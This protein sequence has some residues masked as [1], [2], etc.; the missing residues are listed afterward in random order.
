[1]NCVKEMAHAVCVLQCWDKC[2]L[3]DTAVW[4]PL[5][6]VFQQAATDST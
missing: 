5:F 1:M 2:A 4:L 6:D 3:P